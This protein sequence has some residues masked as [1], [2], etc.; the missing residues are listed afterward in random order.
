LL[1]SP[2]AAISWKPLIRIILN[3][4]FIIIRS[5][6]LEKVGAI[7]LNELE[8]KLRNKLRTGISYYAF[9]LLT[10]KHVDNHFSP[11]MT[12]TE[13]THGFGSFVKRITSV[14]DWF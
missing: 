12:F 3:R 13:I 4:P 14:D 1:K 6:R 11:G 8:N 9:Q 2:L 10:L 7:D 5:P